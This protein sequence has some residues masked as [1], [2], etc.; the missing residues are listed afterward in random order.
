MLDAAKQ[1]GTTTFHLMGTCRMAPDSDPTAVTGG[2]D[3]TLDKRHTV[4]FTAGQPGTW[5]FVVR[6]VGS[7]A[8][9]GAITV[10]D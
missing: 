4:D 7:T 10:R 5:H 1:R 2:P 3:V 6:N 9:T 8:T